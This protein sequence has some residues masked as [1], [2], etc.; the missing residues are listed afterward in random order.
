M[1]VVYQLDFFNSIFNV[2]YF[3]IYVN[4]ILPGSQTQEVLNDMIVIVKEI[5]FLDIT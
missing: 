3:F 2:S 5:F 4:R 1:L